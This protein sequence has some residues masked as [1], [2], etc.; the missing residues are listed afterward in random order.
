MT[1]MPGIQMRLSLLGVLPTGLLGLV[2]VAYFTQ[3]R[4][5]DFDQHFTTRCDLAIRQLAMASAS[6]MASGEHAILQNL[7]NSFAKENDVIK[8]EIFN[9]QGKTLATQTNALEK[10]F[11]LKDDWILQTADI[12]SPTSLS[13]SERLGSVSLVL[14]KRNTFRQQRNTLLSGLAMLLAGM[15]S[16][17]WI[18]RRMGRTISEP[19][20]AVAL[21]IHEM[22]KG[23]MDVRIEFMARGEMAYLQAGFNAM[24]AELKKNR[25][26]LERQVQEA[27]FRLQKT[28]TAL[29]KRNGELET[30][31]GLA[32]A[33]TELK[34]RFLAQMSHEIRTPMNG[35]LGFAELLAKSPLDEGQV[36]KLGLISRSAKNL[37]TISNE[38]LDLSKLEAG[39]I[40]L[41]VKRF[42]LRPTLEDIVSLLCVQDRK[43]PVILWIHQNVPKTIENDPVRLQQVIANL[44][45]NAIKFIQHGRIVIRVRTLLRK[46]RERL[47]FSVSDSG[48]GIS[49]KDIA[50]LFSPFQQLGQLAVSAENGAG[51]GLSIAKNIVQ[52]MGGEIHIASRLGKG[53]SLWFDLPLDWLD[54]Q[55]QKTPPQLLVGLIEPNRLT[56]QALCQQLESLGARVMAFADQ[57]ALTMWYEKV[58]NALEL[59]PSPHGGRPGWGRPIGGNAVELSTLTNQ[60][61]GRQ[62]FAAETNRVS[63]R[64]RD[65]DLLLNSTVLPIGG[66]SSDLNH[67]LPHCIAY[68]ITSISEPGNIP[69]AESLEWCNQRQI[70][71]ILLLQR[72]YRNHARYYR[73]RCISSFELP[74]GSETLGKA[75]GLLDQRDISINPTELQQKLPRIKAGQ[76]M[77]F[78][79]ADDNEIN[80]LLLR[81]QLENFRAE[82]IDACDGNEA[83]EKIRQEP[84]DIIFLDLQMPYLD[85]Q[86]VLK[87]CRECLGPNQHIPVIAITAFCDQEQREAIIRNGFTDCLIKPVAHQQ[88]INRVC[89]AL[90]SKE[91]NVTRSATEVTSDSYV[92]AII[93]KT[94]GNLGLA[95]V[96]ANKLFT[97]LPECMNNAATALAA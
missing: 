17:A 54:Q 29:E 66:V 89:K 91:F 61:V 71:P 60:I 88:M 65:A 32:D 41:D 76:L 14:S 28:L 82:I 24:A 81:A 15:M 50:K 86:T 79:V 55:N 4:T 30:A 94:G 85:G 19:V 45:G 8:V 6:H 62:P 84:F 75:L 47:F 77:R 37:L 95:R 16:A 7:A 57:H 97:E 49:P 48:C 68:G 42:Q 1:I 80:R 93:E 34:S 69:L 22:S 25:D 72:G 3:V 40:C 70:K 73:K 31:R 26:S 12:N 33:Q 27:T 74:I 64:H 53:T 9:S 63:G 44:L 46:G 43:T 5:A 96:I 92:Q 51:L 58:A 20:R 21:A 36:E 23:N 39:K 2:L 83:L 10:I 35:I 90:A 11:Q 56:R 18:A 38:I 67:P 52:S 59:S 87:K 13:G 78:L